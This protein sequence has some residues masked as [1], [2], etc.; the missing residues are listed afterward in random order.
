MQGHNLQDINELIDKTNRLKCSLEPLI[1]ELDPDIPDPI[2]NLILVGKIINDKPLNKA[3]VKN[4]VLKAWNPSSGLKI[5]E[6]EDR[7]LF[8]FKTSQDVQHV[9]DR[10]PWS[11]MGAHLALQPWP[12]DKTIHEV[13]LQYSPFWVR[14]YGLPPNKMTK[15]NAKIIGSRIENLL[16]IEEDSQGR[17]GG[18][19]FMRLKVDVNIESNFPKG[20]I[21]KREGDTESWV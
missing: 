11:I 9:L 18:R 7:L 12:P 1:L 16:E 20:L 15:K 19:G 21:L 14:I 6:I 5:S 8:T 17:I 13:S 10:R 4:T 3:G 2:H